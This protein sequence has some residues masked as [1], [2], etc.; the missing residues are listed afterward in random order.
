MVV[1]TTDVPSANHTMIASEISRLLRGVDSVT[2]RPTHHILH[3]LARGDVALA[4]DH[5]KLVGWLIATRHSDS[6]QELGMA[7]VLP[8]YRRRG[9]VTLLIESLVHKR[10]TTL[11][12]TYEPYL[13]RTLIEKWG[14]R[15]S[16]LREFNFMTK[17]RFLL[18]RIRTPSTLAAVFRHIRQ[19]PPIYLIRQSDDT[20]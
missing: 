13:V 4:F 7:Y 15:S 17:N 1:V 11:A 2:P 12:A 10:R 19:R 14:F 9:I 5:D 20:E 6:T 18:S 8:A 16:S 3:S